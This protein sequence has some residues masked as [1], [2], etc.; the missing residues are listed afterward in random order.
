MLGENKAGANW[1]PA[2][3]RLLRSLGVPRGSDGDSV[4]SSLADLIPQDAGRTVEK[5]VVGQFMFSF[6]H[7]QR[8]CPQLLEIE[9]VVW[10]LESDDLPRRARERNFRLKG[11]AYNVSEEL[12]AAGVMDRYGSHHSKFVLLFF[13]SGLRVIVFTCNFLKIDVEHKSNIVWSQDF[14]TKSGPGSPGGSDFEENLVHYLEAYRGRVDAETLARIRAVDF[15]RASAHFVASVP[16]RHTGA[17][18]N[19][20]GQNR[21]RELLS[22]E[23]F[24]GRFA[25]SPLVLQFSSLSSVGPGKGNGRTKWFDSLVSSF[26]PPSLGAPRSVQI[27]WPSDGCVRRSV[28][29]FAAGCSMPGEK[30]N[31]DKAREQ[32]VQFCVWDPSRGADGAG[33]GVYGRSRNMPHVKTYVRYL[34]GQ[35]GGPPEVAFVLAT[36][37]N[38]SQAAHGVREKNDTQL[39]IKSFEAGVL[40]VPSLLARHGDASF[41]CTAAPSPGRCLPLIAQPCERVRLFAGP[42]TAGDDPAVEVP[43]PYALPPAQYSAADEPYAW[44]EPMRGVD[45][46]GARQS[47]AG[48]TVPQRG[49][50]FSS[51]YGTETPPH[52]P[53]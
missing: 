7:V 23:R 49:F 38:L 46:F 2:A 22:C 25:G 14:P 6:D 30:A 36:S 33:G 27:V 29:G 50:W 53:A 19:R 8:T 10:L 42:A 48:L 15:S 39:F 20:W 44:K 5:A 37:S 9:D 26:S 43:V 35:A 18:L 51:V 45:S 21:V 11:K 34:E 32:H 17:A 3:F 12:K 28:E 1:R 40:V 4:A 24:P 13:A 31:I 41:S 47:G 16:G 52:L